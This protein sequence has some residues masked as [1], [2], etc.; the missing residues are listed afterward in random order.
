MPGALNNSTP[1][2]RCRSPTGDVC[3]CS[4]SATYH[5]YHLPVL[6]H[7]VRVVPGLSAGPSTVEPSSL[8]TVE[9]M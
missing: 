5:M 4:T 2:H 8:T 1:M 3:V 9:E 6:N 7:L